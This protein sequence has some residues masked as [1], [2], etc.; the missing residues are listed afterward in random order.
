[1]AVPIGRRRA[2]ATPRPRPLSRRG[3]RVLI[4]ILA[5][6]AVLYVLVVSFYNAEGTNNVTG[7]LGPVDQ[8]GLI[9]TVEPIGVNPQT[10]QGT[11]DL[12]MMWQGGGLVDDGGHLQQNVRVMINSSVGTQEAKFI[13]GDAL[14]RLETTIGID[15]ELSNYPF[16]VHTGLLSFSADTYTKASDGSF[17]STGPLVIGVQ[18]S[19]GVSG[20]DTTTALGSGLSEFQGMDLTFNRAFSTQ[21]F[22]L[23]LLALAVILS[24]FALVVGILAFTNRRKAEVGLMS[25]TAALLFALPLLR[26]YFP[27]G[28]PVGASIDIFVY[29]WVIVMAVI[30]ATLNVIA[31]MN[32]TR[33]ALNAASAHVDEAHPNEPNPELHHGA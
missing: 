29:L 15:G 16:D 19:G 7:G 28:P 25:W 8:P 21:A 12:N 6:V 2:A 4:A 5:L 31:W 33:D 13:A 1:M 9:I 11:V 24:S 3:R 22:A 18:S 17:Q 20:W 27:Y 14:G 32:Q 10:G 23:V 26:N 30:A